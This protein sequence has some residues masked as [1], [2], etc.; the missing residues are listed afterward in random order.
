MWTHTTQF[1]VSHLLSYPIGRKQR[2]WTL[3]TFQGTE[4]TILQVPFIYTVPKCAVLRQTWVWGAPGTCFPCRDPLPPPSISGSRARSWTCT[5]HGRIAGTLQ[6]PHPI[7]TMQPQNLK[8]ESFN[9]ASAAAAYPS[10]KTLMSTALLP[11]HQWFGSPGHELW[12]LPL[13]SLW[14]DFG[15]A[16]QQ[17]QQQLQ[18]Q[19]KEGHVY[20]T[21]LTPNYMA[22]IPCSQ[23]VGLY[24]HNILPSSQGSSHSWSSDQQ[25]LLYIPC[26]SNHNCTQFVVHIHQG[27]K[28]DTEESHVIVVYFAPKLGRLP[29]GNV[30]ATQGIPWSCMMSDGLPCSPLSS[31]VVASPCQVH[32]PGPGSPSWQSHQH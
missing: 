25:Q 14:P 13:P 26:L 30:L 9:R 4:R 23:P 22:V 18:Q 7:H 20:T 24:M 8:P 27:H 16:Q 3:S 6:A 32:W 10:P 28:G 1:C 2:Y 11:P 29:D 19:E 31:R 15:W 21:L 12:Q 17:E 5:L